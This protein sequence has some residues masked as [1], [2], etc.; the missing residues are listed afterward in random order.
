MATARGNRASLAA[1]RRG[2][3]GRVVVV[4]ATCEDR[5]RGSNLEGDSV[6]CQ[7]PDW[8]RGR[9]HVERRAHRGTGHGNSH[10]H[11]QRVR[12]CWGRALP[13]GMGA[14]RHLCGH[15]LGQ[16]AAHPPPAGRHGA[17]KRGTD[18]VDPCDF[19]LANQTLPP[20]QQWLDAD[21]DGDGVTNGQEVIDGT[22][23]LDGCDLVFTSQTVPPS[24]QWLDGD[25]DGDGVTNGNEIIDGTD[26]TD[27]CDFMLSSQTLPTTPAWEALDCDGDG[28]TNG[29]EIIDGTDPLD[30]CDLVVTSQTL[31]PSTTWNDGDCDGD[32]VTNGQEVID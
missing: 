1:E 11:H 32:G 5:T 13:G 23:P 22:D 10:N 29:Q 4:C 24:Q 14:V 2:R 20:S 6:W 3:I 27:P 31:P 30:E 12:H 17:A 15:G 28:V 8:T 25:C 19:V 26:P 9:L 21:C 7:E 16:G 18:P